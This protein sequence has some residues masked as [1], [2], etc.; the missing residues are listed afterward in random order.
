MSYDPAVD[1]IVMN[2]SISV[3]QSRRERTASARITS[4]DRVTP[5]EGAVCLVIEQSALPTSAKQAFAST[6][7]FVI[8]F[9]ISIIGGPGLAEEMGSAR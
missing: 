4:H 7:G 3:L 5:T 6:F 1:S 8:R 9:Y 2:R